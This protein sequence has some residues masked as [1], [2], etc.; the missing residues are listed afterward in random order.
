[1]KTRTAAEERRRGV[2][3]MIISVLWL[4]GML[5]LWWLVATTN[6]EGHHD[7]ELLPILTLIPLLIAASHFARAH[8]RRR[9]EGGPRTGIA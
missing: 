3:W 4:A 8:F 7:A 6:R 5:A 2:T 9:A 1:M